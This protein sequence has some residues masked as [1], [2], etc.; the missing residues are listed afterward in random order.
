MSNRRDGAPS[1]SYLIALDFD[2]VFHPAKDVVAI[3]FAESTPAWQMAIALRV[4]GRFVW[5]AIFEEFLVT[6]Q[7]RMPEGAHIQFL[8]HSTWRIKFT[9]EQIRHFL[10]PLIADNLINLD[11]VFEPSFRQGATS[12]QYLRAALDVVSFDRLLVIDDRPEI[13]EDGQVMALSK[14][15]PEKAVTFLWCDPDRGVSDASVLH[16]VSEWTEW[17]CL[18]TSRALESSLS[19]SS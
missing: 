18:D 17:T 5:A 2:G 8:I 1:A 14:D 12:D 11:R 19:P 3:N 15:S 4:Q 9:D 13:F 16:A 10:P 6:C 7:S